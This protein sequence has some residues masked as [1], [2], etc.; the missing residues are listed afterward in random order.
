MIGRLAALGPFWRCTCHNFDMDA[1]TVLDSVAR[2]YANLKTLSVEIVSV[3]ES[4]DEV[5]SSRSIQRAKAWFEA[6]DKVRIES[7]KRGWSWSPM[8]FS[9]TLFTLIVDFPSAIP[10]VRRFL[11][12]IFWG[13]FDRITRRWAGTLPRFCSPELPKR[14]VR[15]RYCMGTRVRS[16]LRRL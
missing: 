12:C 5:N 6:P 16:H 10:R 4:G 14:W 2:A 9:G 3:T 13:S 11:A 7:G 15:L 8:A 1:M